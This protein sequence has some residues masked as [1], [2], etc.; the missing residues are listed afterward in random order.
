[1]KLVFH[2]PYPEAESSSLAEIPSGLLRDP[3]KKV[4]AR[5]S[6][7]PAFEQMCGQAA[8][9][10]VEIVALSC[11]RP[12]SVQ[13]N[14]FVEA[15]TK[16]GRGKGIQWLAPP[17]YSEHHTGFTFDL[18][19]KNRPETDDEPPFEHTPA[20]GWLKERAQNFGF[21]L[22][23]PKNNWQGVSYEPWHWRYVR[24]PEAQAMFHPSPVGKTVVCA[25]AL[26]KGIAAAVTALLT[27]SLIFQP[28]ALHAMEK[29]TFK[30]ADGV[31]LV[32]QWYP[33][34]P[35]KSSLI[36]L[37]GLG[38]SKE[39]WQDFAKYLSSKGY[40]ALIYDQRGHGAST[41]TNSGGTINFQQFYGQG[42]D[43]E[44]GKMVYDLFDAVRFLKE[45]R[46]VKTASIAVGGASIGANIAAR[47][48][49][50]HTEVPF[51]I[52]LSPGMN[53]QGLTT[54]D[55]M[56]QL[57]SR[58]VALAASPGDRYAYQS[59]VSLE[60]ML[61]RPPSETFIENPAAGHGVQ[62]F[63]RAKSEQ[64]SELEVKLLQWIQK[65]SL[66]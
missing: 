66:K 62:M 26:T 18:A 2:K 10:K 5:K 15:E 61:S 19:D 55:V 52:L 48:A 11:F 9:D 41:R 38:S 12:C 58:P 3:S 42:L 43:S 30:T 25:R 14:L 60:K 44:W 36:L 64:P 46:G 57:K 45:K 7:L 8:K 54:A 27:L 17:G 51:V 20:F 4:L 35:K 31:Q 63:R 65:Q 53:Y 28:P 23:F 22:S 37:H 29:V 34:A 16:H 39:E 40:G 21:E 49:A 59:V 24:A 6:A 56:P 33:P 13:R 50:V 47:Y 1:M 32:G